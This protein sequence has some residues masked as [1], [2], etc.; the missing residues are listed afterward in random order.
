MDLAQ[1]TSWVD[2]I[3]VDVAKGWIDSYRLSNGQ[4][5]RVAATRPE[6]A[7]FARRASSGLVVLEA[8]GG[9]ERPLLNALARA[10]VAFRLVNPRQARDFARA[11][12]RLAKTDQVD[13][14]VLAEMGQTLALTPSPL[15]DPERER[16]AALLARRE[17][18]VAMTRAEANRLAQASTSDLRRDIASH[19]RV[20]KAHL[21]LVDRQIADHVAES[22]PLAQAAAR[23]STVKGIGPV[24]AATLL[25][26]LPELGRLDRRRIAALAGLAPQACDSG[27]RRGQ[28]HIWGGRANIRRALYLAALTAS[29]YDATIRA[30]RSRL[31]AQGKPTKLILTACTRKLLTILNAMMRD[32]MDYTK[33]PT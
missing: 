21:L 17:D 13:A 20:L 19:L 33:Q 5:E 7:R 12:G 27:L 28:R 4:R 26:R 3:G 30:F 6:L 15:P 1:R 8:S 9:Y 31:Q 11:T 32:G 25:A 24:T 29:R 10:G 23:L 16:L 2:V 14:R 22:A 18:L